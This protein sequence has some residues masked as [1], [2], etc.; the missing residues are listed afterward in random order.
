MG[1]G[2]SNIRST[3]LVK[4]TRVHEHKTGNACKIYYYNRK[5]AKSQK[6]QFSN[7]CVDCVCACSLS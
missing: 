4:Q 6:I 5:K 7:S 1:L 3:K 2:S